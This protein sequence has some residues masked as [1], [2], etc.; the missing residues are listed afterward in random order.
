MLLLKVSN[1]LHSREEVEV[2]KRDRNWWKAILI[3]VG[4]DKRSKQLVSTK[5][6]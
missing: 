4:G 2:I 6:I 3:T 1:Y 5:E